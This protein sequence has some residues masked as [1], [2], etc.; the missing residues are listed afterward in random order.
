MEISQKTLVYILCFV[1][2]GFL[3]IKVRAA[4]V[5]RPIEEERITLLNAIA[6]SASIGAPIAPLLFYYESRLWYY[7]QH[8]YIRFSL[9]V[10]FLLF[11]WPSV[12]ALAANLIV[13]W[14]CW[15]SIRDYLSL[16]SPEVRSW[17]YHFGCRESCFILVT[18]QNGSKIGGY[19]G[20]N[21]FASNYPAPSD[22]YLELQYELDDRNAFIKP[23]GLS[24]GV[25][26]DGASIRYMEFYRIDAPSDN[27]KENSIR[28]S[29]NEQQPPK[30]DSAS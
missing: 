1:V 6:T 5:I 29:E 22:I 8:G 23:L 25:W 12:L 3:F 15:K 4:S 27:V 28:S 9:I 17:D 2:P 20:P 19:F 13:R 18:L 21:S 7:Y 30:D 16:R 11:I 10:I 14:K 24:G 26:I